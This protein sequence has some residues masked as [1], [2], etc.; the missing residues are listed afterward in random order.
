WDPVREYLY[1]FG[2]TIAAQYHD[3][4]FRY[5]PRDDHI[6]W[7]SQLP[8]PLVGAAAGA[9]SRSRCHEQGQWQCGNGNGQA[10][11]FPERGSHVLASGTV[12]RGSPI[13]S[14][15][16]P[17]AVM[18]E[19]GHAYVFSQG[20]WLRYHSSSRQ[21]EEFRVAGWGEIYD[22]TCAYVRSLDRIYIFGG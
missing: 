8:E 18:S 9:L 22:A 2:G 4:I 6:Q 10:F 5:N 13:P 16:G 14:L 19:S 20:T 1:L 15:Y 12:T 3:E 11:I 17:C 7:V 21:V